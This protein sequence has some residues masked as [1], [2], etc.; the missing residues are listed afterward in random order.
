[1]RRVINL[2]KIASSFSLTTLNIHEIEVLK[3]STAKGRVSVTAVL[4]KIG[5]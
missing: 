4:Y 2:V 3:Y 5:G 1:M